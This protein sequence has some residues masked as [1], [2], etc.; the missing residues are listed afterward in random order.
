MSRFVL[1]QVESDAEATRL[2]N[3]INENPGQLLHTPYWGNGVTAT[4][5]SDEVWLVRRVPSG[6][7]RATEEALVNGYGDIDAVFRT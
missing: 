1:L 6:A 3:D 2:I 7:E 4:V 5:V